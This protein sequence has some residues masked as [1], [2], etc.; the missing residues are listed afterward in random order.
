MITADKP[1]PRPRTRAE[2]A[3]GSGPRPCPWVGCRHHL[4]DLVVHDAGTIVLGDHVLAPD[5]DEREIEAFADALAGWLCTLPDSCSLDAARAD[6]MTLGDVG[7]RM[8]VTRERIRQ[9]ESGA[10]RRLPQPIRR[11]LGIT[12]AE[13]RASKVKI[14]PSE[15]EPKPRRLDG[16]PYNRLPCV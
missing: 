8:G 10:L 4:V 13:F 14:Q 1:L 15:G 2:C 6:G 3:P 12:S 9:I 16:V 5:A 11:G 7:K